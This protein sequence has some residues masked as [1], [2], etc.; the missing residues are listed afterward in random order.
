MAVS[1]ERGTGR[2]LRMVKALPPEGSIVVVHHPSMRE[3]VRKMISDVHNR[4]VEA[5]TLVISADNPHIAERHL[6]GR[7]CP[8]FV[9]HA[10][11]DNVSRETADLTRILAQRAN[12]GY[13]ELFA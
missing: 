6:R 12:E 10:F 11:W 2:T 5:S 4:D 9:D 8:V 1:E 13:E 7:V 3:Y